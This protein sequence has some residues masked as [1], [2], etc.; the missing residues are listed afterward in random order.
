M[1]LYIIFVLS[2][3][4]RYDTGRMLT[5]F[6]C[7]ISCRKSHPGEHQFEEN[8]GRRR[9]KFQSGENSRNEGEKM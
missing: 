7:I 5:L 2:L 3:T 1:T 6:V 8:V 4:I 9:I